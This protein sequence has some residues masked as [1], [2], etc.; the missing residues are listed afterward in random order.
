MGGAN[1][2]GEGPRVGGRMSQ[3]RGWVGR[4]GGT[5]RGSR[6]QVMPGVMGPEEG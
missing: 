1:R 4:E 5:A 6:G 2:D 3:E